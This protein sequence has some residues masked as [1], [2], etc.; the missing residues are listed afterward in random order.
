[1]DT[2]IFAEAPSQA[3]DRAAREFGVPHDVTISCKRI[4]E[5]EFM[6]FRIN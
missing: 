5:D 4:A 1:M 6:K 3:I 2:Y